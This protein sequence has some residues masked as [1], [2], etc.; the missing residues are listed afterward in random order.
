MEKF[1]TSFG[2]PIISRV[3]G[4]GTMEDLQE[5]VGKKLSGMDTGKFPSLRE[6][7]L[8]EMAQE[9]GQAS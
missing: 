1:M 8:A 2:V 5:S 3:E 9:E 7:S 6:G 4:G